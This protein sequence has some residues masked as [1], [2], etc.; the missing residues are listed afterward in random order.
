MEQSWFPIVSTVGTIRVAEV[1]REQPGMYWTHSRPPH[2]SQPV[3][4][5]KLTFFILGVDFLAHRSDR[6]NPIAGSRHRKG[7]R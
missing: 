2:S 7:A 5:Q 3:N 1:R 4:F 6:I